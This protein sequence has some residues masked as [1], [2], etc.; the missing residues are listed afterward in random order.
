MQR[1]NRV[2]KRP[3]VELA[4]YEPDIP[5]NTGAMLRLGRCFGL[6]VHVVGPTGFVFSDARLRRAGMDYLDDVELRRHASWDAFLADRH[7]AR[8]RVVLMTTTGECS[9]AL[10]SFRPGDTILMG[11][12]S[13]G[14]PD[15][16]HAQADA[17]LVIPM[18]A[19][20][21]SLNVAQAAAI[22]VAEALRQI[23]ALPVAFDKVAS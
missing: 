21:R 11:R 14:V 9:Y 4:L 23:E 13:A 5:Q 22:A 18:A 15:A 6:L 8:A 10:F 3:S 16:V 12:E 19:G 2:G 17:R 20:A 7:A 1:E